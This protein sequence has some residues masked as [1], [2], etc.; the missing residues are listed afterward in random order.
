MIPQKMTEE[1]KKAAARMRAGKWPPQVKPEEE[2]TGAAGI[3]EAK[4]RFGR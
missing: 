4:K 2:Q 1:Q 3:A